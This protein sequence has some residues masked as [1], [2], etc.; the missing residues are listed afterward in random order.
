VT[1]V[2]DFRRRRP[3][4]RAG[5]GA[6]L[7]PA[8]HAMCLADPAEPRAVL[9]L[10]GIANLTLLRADAPV[11][12]F[13][14]GPANALL[15]AWS[16]HHGE[17]EHD[18]G[19]A[20]AQR[21]RVDATLLA[22]LARRSVLRAAPA[23]KQRPRTTSICVGSRNSYADLRLAPADVQATLVELT[24]S[25]IAEA[26]S[27]EA[28]ATRRVIACGG[29]V[30]NPV[31]MAAIRRTIAPV[32]L[33]SSVS[34]GVDADFLEAMAFAWLARA[35]R[36]RGDPAIC[37]ASP[38]RKDRAC[39]AR[40]IPRAERGYFPSRRRAGTPTGPRAGSRTP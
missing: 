22:R 26:L 38:E 25:S 10:G 32:T 20:F 18:L 6:P 21:G 1:T 34:H 29:G 9:N 19:G 17:G 30:H 12:G 7:L 16:A 39:S 3:S 4:P 2:A 40:S 31:L 11:I 23:E 24:A 14:T 33:D 15:D 35:K 13:D 28:P 37:R 36:S 5:E 27:R 8:F